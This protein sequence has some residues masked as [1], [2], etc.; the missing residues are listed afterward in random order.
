VAGGDRAGKDE[1][2][3]RPGDSGGVGEEPP[4]GRYASGPSF[5][6]DDDLLDERLVAVPLDESAADLLGRLGSGERAE[7]NL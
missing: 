2:D 3:D 7:L 4:E 6:V 1:G 5:V